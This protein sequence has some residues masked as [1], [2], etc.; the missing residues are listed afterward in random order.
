MM[1]VLRNRRCLVLVAIVPLAS[2]VI[3]FL[4]PEATD[5]PA[6]RYVSV[7]YT[8]IMNEPRRGALP[9]FSISNISRFPVQCP[10]VGSQQLVTNRTRTRTNVDWTWRPQWQSM[11]LN[12]GECVTASAVPPT[13]GL[14]W[15]F[16]VWVERPRPLSQRAIETLEPHLPRRLYWLLR[17]DPRRTQLF[18]SRVFQPGEFGSGEWSPTRQ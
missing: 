13:N 7:G 18:Q 3:F 11:S 17:G 14:P 6:P 15:R 1:W 16:A 9:Q 4:W 10:F 12:S 5:R 8:G 2:L